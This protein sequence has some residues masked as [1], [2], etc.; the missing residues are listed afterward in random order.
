M[1]KW[2]TETAGELVRY[3]IAPAVLPI[4]ERNLVPD[5]VIRTGMRR[6]LAMELAKTKKYNIE[7]VMQKTQE[8]VAE[9]KTMP[10]A[11]EQSA[12]N[13]QHYE[14][15]DEFYRMVLGPHLKYSSGLWLSPTTTI[16]ESE[17]AMLELYCARAQLFDGMTLI[18]LGCGWGSVSLYM[19]A[20][21]PNS[22]VISI[23]NSNSQR[24]YILS[25]A[26]SRGLSNIQV[27]T[28]DINEFDLP[29]EYHGSADRIISIEMFEHMKNYQKLLKKVSNWLKTEGKLF[30][31]IF[32]SKEVSS[33][34]SN[35]WMADNFFSGGTLPSDNLLLY[36]QEDVRIEN[37]W[38]VNGKHYSKTLEAWLVL[39]DTQQEKI[40]KLFSERYSAE[41]SLKRFVNWRL[42]F[43]ACSEFF[44]IAD[45][46]EYFVSHY[47]FTKRI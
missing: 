36:F 9:L 25:T 12:A 37:H 3:H 39:H 45:G 22:K 46:E 44:G 18:D 28:G 17:V 34:F 38:R 19:A 16:E 14:V 8:F 24:E 41:E 32:T 21:Y 47:L 42:F 10:I 27:F 20:K 2:A 33:H 35:G 11:L 1:F 15:P 13:E 30:I 29:A 26:A 23:S 5:I 4:V 43:L 7:E 31:H 6:E 40:L